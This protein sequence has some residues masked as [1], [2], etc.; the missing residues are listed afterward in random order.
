[1]ELN[2]TL[3]IAAL[4]L[5]AASGLMAKPKAQEEIPGVAA[6]PAEF[7]YTGK[8]YDKDLGAYLFNYRN[9]DAQTSRWTSADPSGFPDGAN[10]RF[11]APVP[12]RQLDRN[13]LYTI[14]LD[15]CSPYINGPLWNNT[16]LSS[17]LDAI[18][19]PSDGV[20]RIDLSVTGASATLSVSAQATGTYT[21]ITD[22]AN[23]ISLLCGGSGGATKGLDFT[24]WPTTT[25]GTLNLDPLYATKGSGD[26]YIGTQS[27]NFSD[28]GSCTLPD[29]T[30]LNL[31]LGNGVVL[32]SLTNINCQFSVSATLNVDTYE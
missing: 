14:S 28:G 9:L 29:L 19:L 15:A 30:G 27:Q 5:F 2:K 7:F 32:Y 11:Y 18:N 13:G 6:Q 4:S 25:S 22:L 26:T 21:T 10:N 16:L 3:L 20:N 24:N 17:A 8:P 1:M 23:L 12:T 31:D